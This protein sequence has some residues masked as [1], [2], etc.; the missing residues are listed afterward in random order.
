MK[1]PFNI[2]EMK[3]FASFGQIPWII[4]HGPKPKNDKLWPQQNIERSFSKLSENFEIELMIL[5]LLLLKDVQ[6]PPPP[7]FNR[8]GN[9]LSCHNL[10]SISTIL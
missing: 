10:N 7:P 9:S 8:F 3:E 4:A 6:L 1:G 5:M 2:W